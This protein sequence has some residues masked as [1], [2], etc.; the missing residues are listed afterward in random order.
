MKL[1]AVKYAYTFNFMLHH[2]LLLQIR[3]IYSHYAFENMFY[4][5]TMSHDMTI[6]VKK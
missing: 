2:P 4:Q 3:D 1:V 5:Y 6:S